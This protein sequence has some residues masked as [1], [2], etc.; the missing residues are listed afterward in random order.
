MG[1]EI[2]ININR[3]GFRVNV[4]STVLALLLILLVSG[5]CFDKGNAEMEFR[6]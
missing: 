6:S 4:S 2:S 1:E 5:L 3:D